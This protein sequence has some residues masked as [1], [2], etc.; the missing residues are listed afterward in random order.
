M[1]VKFKH[2]KVYPLKYFQ[3]LTSSAIF[4]TLR[5][6]SKYCLALLANALRKLVVQKPNAP[7]RL[8]AV[9][10]LSAFLF[11]IASLSFYDK[12]TKYTSLMYNLP[13]A[14]SI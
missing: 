10:V 9:P 6:I 7:Q 8:Q 13:L 1:Q 14:S 2:L 11:S 5:V 12:A 3:L 4:V